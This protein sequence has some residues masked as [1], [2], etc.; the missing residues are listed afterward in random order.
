MTQSSRL[1]LVLGDQLSF[2]LASLQNLNPEHD[3]VLLVEVM[4]E[5][6]HVPHHPQKIALIFSAMR[7]FAEA[8]RERGIR[9]QYVTLDDPDNAGSVP[10]ELRRWQAALHAEELHVTECGDWRLEQS[11]KDCGLPIHWHADTRFLCSRDEFSSWAHGKKQLRMEFF[12]REMRR[13][14]GLLRNGGDMSV[15]GGWKFDAKTSN[16]QPTG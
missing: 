10:G 5:A 14:S 7:H 3:T 2:D 8:L 4:E 11:I 13:K 16:A 1:H 15:G 9:V 12:Y 6:T